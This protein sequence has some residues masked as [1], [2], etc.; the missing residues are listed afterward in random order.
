MA[1]SD[2]DVDLLLVTPKF[3]NE[4]KRFVIEGVPPNDH[5][6][7]AVVLGQ[8]RHAIEAIGNG[9]NTLCAVIHFLNGHVPDFAWGSAENVARWEFIKKQMRKAEVGL[10]VVGTLIATS[11][12]LC[13]WICR[14]HHTVE[15]FVT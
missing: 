11:V 15:Q 4:L 7:M 3:R 12:M 1:P 8:F 13:H 6:L 14:H 2:F 5:A 9:P 10:L